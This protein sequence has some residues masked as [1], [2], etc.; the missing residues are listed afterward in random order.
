MTQ[1]K[2]IP[3]DDYDL[4]IPAFLTIILMPFTYSITNGIG[5]GFVSFVVIK[6][7]RG[8]ARD[9]HPLLWVIAALFLVYFA[10]DLVERG[11]GV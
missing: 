6:A 2:H 3:W 8:K 5:A 11:L 1:V 7:T 4:A 9:V 10:I